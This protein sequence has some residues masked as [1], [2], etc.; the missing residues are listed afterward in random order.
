MKI[1]KWKI[2]IVLKITKKQKVICEVFVKKTHTL[3]TKRIVQKKRNNR[4]K[5][6]IILYRFY[7]MRVGN[8][9]WTVFFDFHLVQM[10]GRRRRKR[11]KTDLPTG[12]NRYVDHVFAVAFSTNPNGTISARTPGDYT[13]VTVSFRKRWLYR[14]SVFDDFVVRPLSHGPR[15]CPTSPV[16]QQR[17]CL[18]PSE[19]E[20]PTKIVQNKRVCNVK[21][22]VE[23]Y[24]PNTVN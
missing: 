20:W 19:H 24:A 14:H 22:D 17:L 9:L 18:M 21:T 4:L 23:K 3:S 12:T 5:C 16:V 8:D 2:R 15:I 7:T 13:R 1:R 10:M 11:I 6:N